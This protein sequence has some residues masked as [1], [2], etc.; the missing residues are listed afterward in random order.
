M[1]LVP[2]DSSLNATLAE[3]RAGKFTHQ[4]Q[5]ERLRDDLAAQ[6]PGFKRGQDIILDLREL[7]DLESAPAAPATAPAPAPASPAPVAAVPRAASPADALMSE[8]EAVRHDAKALS[9]LLNHPE[10]GPKLRAL[11]VSNRVPDRQIE[12]APPSAVAVPLPVTAETLALASTPAPLTEL[13][14][15]YER[16]KTSPVLLARFLKAN[17]PALR[18]LLIVGA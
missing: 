10:K 18:D 15:I 16:V 3:V 12:D 11:A 17:A 5:C 2:K 9:V 8:Y 4:T 13:A 1:K 6:Q 14:G 7:L